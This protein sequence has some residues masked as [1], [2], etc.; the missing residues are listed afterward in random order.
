M[1]H[2]TQLHDV[3]SIETMGNYLYVEGETDTYEFRRAFEHIAQEA[4]GRRNPGSSSCVSPGSCK[5]Y[6]PGVVF[7]GRLRW[8]Q[9]QKGNK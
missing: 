4:L 1:A 3:V 2:E 6:Q 7:H 8:N 5:N 9:P